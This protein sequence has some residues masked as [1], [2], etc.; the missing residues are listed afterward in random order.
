MKKTWT[1]FII[2]P[3]VALSC[4]R[5]EVVKELNNPKDGHSA[6]TAVSSDAPSCAS[7]GYTLSSGIDLNDNGV[8]DASEITSA[9]QVCNG[10]NG[11]NGQNGSNGQ[12]GLD[13]QQGLPGQ[14]G[15][16]GHNSLVSILSSSSGGGASCANGGI[17]LFSG[18]DLNDSGT[19]TISEIQ[20]SADVC[21][22]VNGQDAPQNPFMPVGL[23]DPCGPS[24]GQDE[25]FLKLSNGT[26]VASFS[27]NTAGAYTRLSVLK[28]GVNYMTTDTDNCYFS[29]DSNGNLYNQHH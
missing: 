22:G 25:V 5:K 17:T 12:D 16:N 2:V 19:L 7:G 26:L 21:N 1:A 29:V 10:T 28:P 9:T 11:T 4:A 8:L 6:V 18:V 20:Y 13:G 27:N 15:T 3:L 24:G 14:N 23:V